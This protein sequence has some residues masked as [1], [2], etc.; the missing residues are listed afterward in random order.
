MSD[1]FLYRSKYHQY[2]PPLSC[3]NSGLLL[4][5]MPVWVLWLPAQK[6]NS[7]KLTSIANAML[8]TVHKSH[9]DAFSSSNK[10]SH[11]FASSWYVSHSNILFVQLFDSF[12]KHCSVN[13]IIAFTICDFF[14]KQ[15]C[16]I[17]LQ[18]YKGISNNNALK[19]LIICL[20]Y[21]VVA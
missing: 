2:N 12:I 9:L 11:T 1:N 14:R 17:S 13:F 16:K 10:T 4:Q 19:S 20:Y 6:W 21:T 7:S 18:M 5:I 3:N 8:V 15:T